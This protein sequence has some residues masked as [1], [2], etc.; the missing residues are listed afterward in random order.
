MKTRVTCAASLIAALTVPV[1][2]F[3]QPRSDLGRFEYVNSCASCHG[4]SGKG[5]GP[6]ARQLT[7]S[8]SN[9]TTLTKR[10]EGVFPSARVFATI[11]GRAT[12]E[13]LF[14]GSRDMPV[15]GG[16][17]SAR[18]MQPGDAPIDPERYVRGRLTA[19]VDYLWRIQEK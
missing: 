12:P 3:A 18:A 7:K 9:L 16:E 15:W 17:F 13:I 4:S 5:D 6:L 1:L 2:S 8:P 19:L 10:N 14:H 11:D